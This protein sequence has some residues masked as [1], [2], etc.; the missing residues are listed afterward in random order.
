MHKYSIRGIEFNAHDTEVGAFH[1]FNPDRPEATDREPD[2]MVEEMSAF[3]RITEEKRK[4]LDVGALFG[5]FSLVFTRN[6][7][8]V[9][10]AFEPSPYA[11]PILCDHVN[12]NPQH[13]IKPMQVFVGEKSGELV[14]C[15]RDWKH[16]V[17]NLESDDIITQSSVS[18]D[19]M[20]LGPVD[21]MKID[22]E[23]YECQVLRGAARTI[24]RY[25]PVIFLECHLLTLCKNQETHETLMR[26]IGDLGYEAKTFKGDTVDSFEPFVNQSKMTR[27]VLYPK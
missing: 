23:S 14:Q 4:L 24:T 26:I 21:C 1:V 8:A 19:D 6:K 22:V 15:G 17:A 27:V 5:V 13:N 20:E 9:A 10:Y 25:K 12:N 2:G 11:F 7:D 16:I 18:I 3:I